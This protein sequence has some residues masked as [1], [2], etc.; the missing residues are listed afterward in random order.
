M[1]DF[2]YELCIDI[3]LSIG[4]LVLILF[5]FFFLLYLSRKNSNKFY[6]HDLFTKEHEDFVRKHFNPKIH[7]YRKL[8]FDCTDCNNFYAYLLKE[9]GNHDYCAACECILTEDNRKDYEY[10]R[11]I[12]RS[13]SICNKCFSDMKSEANNK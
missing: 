7:K 12:T 11:Q 13:D 10:M 3:F 4:L 9:S 2:I 1:N 5:C 8:F 6:D